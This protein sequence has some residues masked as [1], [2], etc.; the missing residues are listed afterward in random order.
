MSPESRSQASSSATDASS[1][2]EVGGVILAGGLA[3]RMEGRDK[4]L[5]PLLNKP[6]V[7]WVMEAL[8]PQVDH[9]ILNANRNQEAYRELGAKVVADVH[10]GHLGPLAGLAS[11]MA[12]LPHRYIFMCPCDSPFL[13][14]TMVADL[15]QAL[16]QQADIAVACDDERLQP[17]FLLAHRRVAPSLTAF[18]DAG[19]RKIDR[20]FADL[21]TVSVN[22]SHF[23]QVFTNINSE[24][25]REKVEALL[26]RASEH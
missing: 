8:Q 24:P 5:I 1:P 11:G 15:L 13:P 22:F 23:P 14:A 16:Q 18:L 25:E 7:Q 21:N 6:M 17:V 12:E 10:P 26:E 9:L 19:E 4:G 20:W 3:R 2:A